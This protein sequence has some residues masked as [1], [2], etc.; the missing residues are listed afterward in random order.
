M[1]HYRE[2]QRWTQPWLRLVVFGLAAAIWFVAYRQIVGADPVSGEPIFTVLLL[3]S[4]VVAGIG[5]PALLLLSALR[6]EVRADGI[7]VRFAP[8]HRRWHGWRFDEI[9]DIEPRQYSP[10]REYGGW[11]IRDGRH[12]RAYNVRGNQGVQLVLRS[13]RRVLIGTQD[14]KA[15]TDAIARAR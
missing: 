10:L 4:W 3:A 9:A 6:T 7:Y 1:V 5:I 2:T 14:P 12:G 11:G 15:M 8:F 13:G